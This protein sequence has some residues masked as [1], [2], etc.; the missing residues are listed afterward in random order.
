MEQTWRWFGADDVIQ[1][2]H[3]RQAGATEWFY[4]ASSN[5]CDVVWSVEKIEVR[6]GAETDRAA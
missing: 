3:I 4:H 6:K 5:P 1:L 2:G